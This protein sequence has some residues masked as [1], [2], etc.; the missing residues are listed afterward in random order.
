MLLLTLYVFF[1]ILFTTLFFT[2]IFLP[3]ARNRSIFPMFRKRVQEIVHEHQ[4]LEDELYAQELKKF[5][6]RLKQKLETQH[7]EEQHD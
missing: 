7:N 2:Q 1:A 6:D 5:N 3:I 4:S